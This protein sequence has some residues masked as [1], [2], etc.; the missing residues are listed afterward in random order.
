MALGKQIRRYRELL[1]WT[2]EELS[3]ASNV[4]VGTIS[5]LEIRDSSRSKFA[6]PLAKAFGFTLEQLSD[7]S[8]SLQPNPPNR[9]K[10]VHMASDGVTNYS[11][12]R[13][14]DVWINEAVATLQKLNAEDRRAAVLNLRRF[15]KD[16]DPHT[17]GQALS[18]AG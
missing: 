10:P 16:M 7:E 8:A 4:E 5:A 1:G 3:D 9:Q 18:V 11:T 17:D 12:Q 15:V 13:E 6:I 14:S 2:L